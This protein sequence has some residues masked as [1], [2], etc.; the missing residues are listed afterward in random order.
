MLLLLPRLLPSVPQTPLPDQ[1]PLNT[2]PDISSH[3]HPVRDPTRRFRCHPQRPLPLPHRKLL[4][5]LLEAYRPNLPSHP[6]GSTLNQ[7]MPPPL[8]CLLLPR[9]SIIMLPTMVLGTGR[10]GRTDRKTP[11]PTRIAIGPTR[12]PESRSPTRRPRHL[13]SWTMA[14]P[15]PRP[16][17]PPN[18]PRPPVLPPLPALPATFPH[19]SRIIPRG[20]MDRTSGGVI[21]PQRGRARRRTVAYLPGRTRLLLFLLLLQTRRTGRTTLCTPTLSLVVDGN[22]GGEG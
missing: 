12:R 2:L 10:P 13:P 15:P 8:S 18:P 14:C 9:P 3:P 17:L 16:A 1:T 7:A 20:I 5:P 22:S 11:A 19:N 21:H 4:P 6:K